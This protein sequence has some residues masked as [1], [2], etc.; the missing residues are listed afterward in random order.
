MSEFEFERDNPW[1]ETI[2]KSVVPRRL[3]GHMSSS[4]LF[5]VRSP[6]CTTRNFPN[7]ITLPTDWAF[8]PGSGSLGLSLLQ[9]GFGAPAPG[10]GAL[11]RPPP[12]DTTRQSRPATGIL[13]PALAIV[14]VRSL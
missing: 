11:M 13:S 14:C 3:F 1:C 6:R 8:S 5:Q 10:S 9:Y 12:A 7:V 2:N 4:S